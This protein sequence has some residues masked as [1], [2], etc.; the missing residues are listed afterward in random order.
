MIETDDNM[1]PA[2]MS[3]ILQRKN[4]IVETCFKECL[5]EILHNNN[6]LNLP[7]DGRKLHQKMSSFKSKYQSELSEIS[8]KD[9]EMICPSSK[10]SNSEDWTVNVLFAV[11]LNYL[12]HSNHIQKHLNDL[13]SIFN[14]LNHG[15][16][17]DYLRSAA[18]S[19][20]LVSGMENIL[21]ALNYSNMKKFEELKNDPIDSFFMQFVQIFKVRFSH[22]QDDINDLKQTI[23]K[24]DNV[25]NEQDVVEM[26]K[27]HETTCALNSK[28]L[29]NLMKKVK[30]LIES[31]DLVAAERRSDDENRKHL[32]E[33]VEKSKGFESE[34][35]ELIKEYENLSKR[36]DQHEKRLKDCE[37]TE[38]R[39]SHNME[40]L[41]KRMSD[42]EMKKDGITGNIF[43]MK[44][45][46]QQA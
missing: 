5:L 7:K 30:T 43:Y 44:H 3:E 31:A 11:V 6:N 20:D 10:T 38:K 4:L 42:L 22:V 40:D 32:L 28:K 41:Q 33:I 29:K 21:T 26:F 12:S 18:K 36:V 15:E 13:R 25:C 2:E 17:K 37:E 19:N 46:K 8:T 35:K 1:K 9:W 27:E 24:I 45:P 39:L 34:L 23:C 14:T 16:V